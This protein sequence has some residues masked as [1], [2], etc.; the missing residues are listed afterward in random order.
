MN[1][2]DYIAMWHR[3]QQRHEKIYTTEFKKALQIQVQQYLKRNSLT[4]VTSEPIYKVLKHLYETVGPLWAQKTMVHRMP[5][6]T[7]SRMIMGFAQRIIELMRQYYG[8]DLLNDA[9]LMTTISRQYIADVLS[10][11]ALS[12]ISNDEIVKQL[13]TNPEFTAM[14]ARRIART[15]TVTA[16][17]SAAIINAKESGF[18]MNKIWHAVEDKRTRHSHREVDGITVDIDT[19][20]EVGTALMQQPGV[21]TQPNGL[22]VPA[23]EVVNC[24]CIVG[25]VGKRDAEGRLI[26]NG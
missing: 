17:N 2:Q 4:D 6:E 7:K 13:T 15:E 25:F 22:D 14:R 1:K 3:F 20:F 8:M 21:R 5:V 11:A 9:E 26:R 18:K 10:A 12:G 24:R 19:P 16:S 23:S